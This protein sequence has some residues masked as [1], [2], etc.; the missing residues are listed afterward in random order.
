MPRLPSRLVPN[1]LARLIQ[2]KRR[3]GASIADLT[4]S[5]PTRVGLTYPAD[6][7]APLAEARALAYDP[8][9]L[10]MWSARAAVAADFRR[11]G[12]VLSADRVALT[13]STSEAYTLLFK[14]LCV[15]CS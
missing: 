11:R 3:S 12:I 1:A 7:L 2:S 10:G 15:R 9:P 13:S 14:L 5:N 8:Q 4:E 6:L